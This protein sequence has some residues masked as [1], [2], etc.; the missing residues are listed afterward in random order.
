VDI[1]AWPEAE[2]PRQ[3]RSQVNA[4]RDEAWPPDQPSESG[5][6]HDPALRPLSMLLVDDGRVLAALDI[7][8]KQI[9][10]RGEQY[11]ASG[12]STMVTDSAERGHGHGRALARAARE[13]MSSTGADL[14]L[15]TCDPPLQGFYEGA[16]W[17]VL[18]GTVLVG[19]TPQ[20]P[21]PSDQFDKITM[22]CFFSARARASA[23]AFIG[24]RI[25]LYP[26]EIDKL[27]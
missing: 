14:G 13:R 19:G 27:W 21:L 7:L 12:L 6:G 25:E 1:L 17:Q 8:S 3:L 16:G 23:A 11:A 20:A 4:L 18:P 15:F 9:T 2:V 5:R 10:H 22:G 26:G 24:C